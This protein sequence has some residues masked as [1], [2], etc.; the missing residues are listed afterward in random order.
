MQV[1][2]LYGP[3]RHRVRGFL[4]QYTS[5]KAVS[6]T[7]SKLMHPILHCAEPRVLQSP[8]LP[9]PWP[10]C[11]HCVRACR[12]TSILA[13]PSLRGQR[14][15][16][17]KPDSPHHGGRPSQRGRSHGEHE[18]A[19]EHEHE[20]VCSC[21]TASMWPQGSTASLSEESPAY[22]SCRCVHYAYTRVDGHCRPGLGLGLGLGLYESRRSLPAWSE[23]TREDDS[24]ARVSSQ[25]CESTRE[26]THKSAAVS[27][28]RCE[29]YGEGER[30]RGSE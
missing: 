9:A 6:R 16:T 24:R 18:H 30:V 13:P 15:Q 14:L 21:L 10:P 12:P 25:R 20:H 17:Y 1:R 23:S 8:L 5:T 29:C 2:S 3:Y 11:V 28:Q 7:F 22:V 4:V 19:H 26:G 27:S